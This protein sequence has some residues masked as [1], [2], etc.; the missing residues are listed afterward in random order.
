MNEASPDLFK[1]SSIT[2]TKTDMIVTKSILKIDRG[3]CN[4]CNRG[5]LK[6]DGHGLEYPYDFVYEF[7]RS[8]G[9]GFK[10]SI[11]EDCLMELTTKVNI[12]ND[13]EL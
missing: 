8:G 9:N 13:N 5:R 3:S 11:C 2:G 6:D 12:I 7:I 10:A 1:G 4:F